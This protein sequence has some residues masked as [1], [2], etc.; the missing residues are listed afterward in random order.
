MNPN[1]T[2]EPMSVWPTLR[3]KI[4]RQ[5]VGM[6]RYFQVSLWDACSG[7]LVPVM[8]PGYVQVSPSVFEVCRLFT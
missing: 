1:R 3:V 6:N 2:P 8:F 5:K 4:S 7:K